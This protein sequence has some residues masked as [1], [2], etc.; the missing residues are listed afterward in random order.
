MTVANDELNKEEDPLSVS[1]ASGGEGKDGSAPADSVLRQAQDDREPMIVPGNNRR[2]QKRRKPRRRLFGKRLK[3]AFLE[4]F[5]CTANVAAS[6]AAV[7]ISEGVVYTHRRKDPEFRD[8]FWMALE[9]STA[10][11]VALRV[12][13]ELERAARA[14]RGHSYTSVPGEGLELRL[15]GPPDEKQIAD[16]MKLMATMRDLCRGLSGGERPGGRTPTRAS[17]EETCRALAKRLKAFDARVKAGTA[18]KPPGDSLSDCP[19]VKKCGE[20]E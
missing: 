3:E 19:P 4:H 15:D 11:L 13:R 16:L 5:S 17:V 9:Q 10:K 12:Q 6:A 8:G 18:A 1:P 7:G 2:M 20:G 14:E